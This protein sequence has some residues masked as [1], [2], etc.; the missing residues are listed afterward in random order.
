[1][2]A[3]VP[4]KTQGIAFLSLTALKAEMGLHHVFLSQNG[5]LC[6][7]YRNI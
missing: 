2:L 1:M 6:Q 5:S 7:L 3:C 4:E